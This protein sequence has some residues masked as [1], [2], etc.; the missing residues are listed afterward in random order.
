MMDKVQEMKIVSVC[1]SIAVLH[2]QC[3]LEELKAVKGKGKGHPRTGH[4][5]PEGE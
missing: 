4:Q 3:K 5:G 2:V 1:F